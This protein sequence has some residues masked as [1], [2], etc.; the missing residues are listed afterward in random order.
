MRNN[1]LYVRRINSNRVLSKF[2]KKLHLMSFCSLNERQLKSIPGFKI[3]YE[4]N[5]IFAP[6]NDNYIFRAIINKDKDPYD[7][8]SRIKYNPN[9]QKRSR[10][11]IIGQ[12]IGYYSIG[13]NNNDAYAVSIVEA[14]SDEL[15]KS[16]KYNFNLTLS[17]WKIKKAIPINVVCHSSIAQAAGTDLY[18]IYKEICSNRKLQLTRGKYRTWS[19]STKF[20][21]NQFSKELINCDSDYLMSSRYSNTVTAVRKFL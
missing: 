7:S 17:K 8:I 3:F 1:L 9:P 13:N 2:L 11:N 6:T 12:G 21:A 18:K 20:I 19:L 4:K 14:C 10:A 15:R 16:N 5:E